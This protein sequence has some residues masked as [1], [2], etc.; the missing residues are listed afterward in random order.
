MKSVYDAIKSLV[1]F[2]PLVV[3]A[4]TNGAVVDS[5]GFNTAKLVVAAGD[6][7]TVDETYTYKIQEGDIS[8]LSDA[9]DVAGASGAITADNEV[10]QIRLDGLANSVRKRYFRAVLT[11][12]G[13]NPSIAHSAMFE[14]GNAYRKSVN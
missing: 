14:F 10:L 13:S 9:V 7:T 12:A 11:V 6:L 1:S 8:D 3:T 4:N 5:K 2:V